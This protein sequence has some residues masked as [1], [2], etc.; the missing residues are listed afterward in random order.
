VTETQVYLQPAF[1]L[2]QRN[3]RE[4]S[5]ILDVFTRDFGRLS[6][7]A[8]GVRKAKSK[9][10]GL[11]QPFIPL[12]VSYFGKAELKTLSA[13]EISPPAIKLT[14]M[15]LYCGFYVN[16]LVT[17][18][19]HQ[20]DPHPEVFEGYKH[21]LIQLSDSASI[22]AVLR[23]F[24][25][26]L[27]GAIGYGLHWAQDGPVNPLT[28]YRYTIDAGLVVAEQGIV[29][30][31]TLIEMQARVFSG[32]DTLVEAKRLMRIVI[33]SHLQGKPLKSRAVIN[34]IIKHL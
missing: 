19:L 27:I 8:K 4:T 29:S 34:K 14:G 28:Q 22:E 32:S 30:E 10:A 17:S 26:D 7:V 21:C 9:T 20:H 13:V 1:I 25:F 11:L 5:L 3:Y 33:D 2:R 6:L 16:E 18:L 23:V 12:V 31:K 24:E 15:A